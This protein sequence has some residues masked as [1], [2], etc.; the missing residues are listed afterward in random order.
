[1]SAIREE[2]R[3]SGGQA[4]RSSQT[5]PQDLWTAAMLVLVYHV[6]LGRMIKR[7][8]PGVAAGQALRSQIGA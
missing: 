6:W 5:E 2:P 8:V 1:V 7:P 4:I 3:M